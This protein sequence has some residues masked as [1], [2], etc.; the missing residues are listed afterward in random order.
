MS[1]RTPQGPETASRQIAA[2]LRAAIDQGD[3]LPGD[4]LPSERELAAAHRVARNTAR[5][6]VRQLAEA[7]LVV[8]EHGRGVFVRTKPRLMRFGQRRYSKK[9][10]DETE[11]SPFHAEVIAQERTPN[12]YMTS[13]ERVI[14]PPEIAERLG[15][16]GDTHS[17]VR[18]ENWY[19]AD[20]EPMQRGVTYIPWDIA[21][22]SALG[23]S[24]DLGPGDLYARFEDKGHL[25]TYTREEVTAR[26]PSPEE[27]SGL[28][29]P[30]GVPVLVVLHTGL[31]QDHQPFEV[32]EFVMRADYTGLDYTMKVDE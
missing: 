23:G 31:D 21:K 24:D 17:V 25:I 4:K 14:P 28:Q 26:M 27:A 5:E 7:G 32:T 15:V 11:I 9:L 13:I 1:E 29:L 12:A 22:D 30:D 18:R 2:I 10:R 16:S 20:A 8:A 6:A 19:F 3:L